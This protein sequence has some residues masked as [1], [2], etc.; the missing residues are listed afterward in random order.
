MKVTQSKGG[1]SDTDMAQS[2]AAYLVDSFRQL[3]ATEIGQPQQGTGSGVQPDE[4]T[5]PLKG[6]VGN[7][8]R[9]IEQ[10]TLTLNT[11]LNEREL[12]GRDP[13]ERQ[14]T[15]APRR[16]LSN[17]TRSEAGLY[18][19]KKPFSSAVGPWLT[20]NVTADEST[21]T[22]A[23]HRE[24]ESPRATDCIDSPGESFPIDTVA[25]TV[26]ASRLSTYALTFFPDHPRPKLEM[27]GILTEVKTKDLN[28]PSLLQKQKEFLHLRHL[29]Q[30]MATRRLP[31]L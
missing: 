28:G 3:Q 24:N 16:T 14:N 6:P 15:S 29:P 1:D 21:A 25:T 9:S 20:A 8:A 22:T 10:E 26:P 27:E 2:R 12:I 7:E 19:G 18:L 11:N 13:N 17:I 31:S 23:D 4:A 30:V 5:G